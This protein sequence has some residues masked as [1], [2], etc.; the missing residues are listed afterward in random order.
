MILLLGDTRVHASTIGESVTANFDHVYH[1]N[2]TNRSL[3]VIEFV[4]QLMALSQI[5]P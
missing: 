3:D 4:Q 1:H 2:Q 5:A